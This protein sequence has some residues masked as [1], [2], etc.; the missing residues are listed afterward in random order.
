VGLHTCAAVARSLCVSRAFLL[1]LSGQILLMNDKLQSMTC[2]IIFLLV[3][4]N[5]IHYT[6]IHAFSP[7]VCVIFSLFFEFK[8]SFLWVFIK[9]VV[10]CGEWC[11]CRCSVCKEQKWWPVVSVWRL[12]CLGHNRRLRRR[13]YLLT[14]GKYRTCNVCV[15]HIT[16]PI[17]H[18]DR[19]VPV[20]KYNPKRR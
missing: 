20:S 2:I 5:V 18:H 8:C 4:V 9:L 7:N 3:I 11:W 15:S 1:Y 14:V 17:M 10:Q 16:I 6:F 19:W 12:Q 13:E